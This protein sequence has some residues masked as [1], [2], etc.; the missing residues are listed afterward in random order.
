MM[1]TEVFVPRGAFTHQELDGLAQRLTMRGLYGE[2]EATDP[3]VLEFLEGITHVVVHELDVWVAG[4]RTVEAGE[5]S[6]YVV[7]VHVPGAWRKDL[8]KTLVERV[9]RVLAEFDP[10]PERLYGKPHAEVHVLSVPDGGYGVFGR[11]V[12]QSA[13]AELI[14]ATKRGTVEA[15]AGTAIDPACGCV[16]P[17]DGPDTITAGV[18]GVTYAFCCAGCR[19]HFLA[20]KQDKA[21]AR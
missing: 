3:G 8:S 19:Q 15:P 1:F 4:G 16:V 17:L 14:S 6:R 5:P 11:V 13:M 18:D 12:G 9:T 21:S 20:G 2:A 7:R 10:E